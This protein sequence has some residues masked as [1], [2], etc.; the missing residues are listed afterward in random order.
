MKSKSNMKD[1]VFNL[2]NDNLPKSYYYHNH[3]HTL[4]V[5]DKV[6]LIG[7][8]EGCNAEE[9]KLLNTA[10]L[11]HD[12]GYIHTYKNHEEES[13]RLAPEHLP[14]FGYTPMDIQKIC[15]MIMATRL[16]QSPNTKLEE[17]LADADLEYLGSN[18]YDKKA[19]DLYREIHHLNPSLT[20]KKWKT[21][22]ITFLQKHHFF[23]TFCKEYREPVKQ[24]H[25]NRLHRDV[26]L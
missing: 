15:G 10:A 16:P 23:T 18:D 2:L 7:K 5:A 13:C 26:S 19:A 3:K 1:F 20:E 14:G 25:L 6:L 21:A 8:H 17:I 11:W 4:Y 12:S 9:L 24:V 22:Q